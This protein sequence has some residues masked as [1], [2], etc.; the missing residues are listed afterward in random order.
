[1]PNIEEPE[2]G[3]CPQDSAF[4]ANFGQRNVIHS[5]A[6]DEADKTEDPTYGISCSWPR[7]WLRRGSVVKV[8]Y[9]VKQDAGISI[10]SA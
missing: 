1:M 10:L 3:D 6:T 8:I 7:G 9:Q 5:W 4:P 2:N